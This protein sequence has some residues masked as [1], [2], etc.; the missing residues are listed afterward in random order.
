MRVIVVLDAG[1]DFISTF[2]ACLYC[3]M[4]NIPCPPAKSAHNLKLLQ[5]V[6]ADSAAD[7]LICQAH[8]IERFAE[9]LPQINCYTVADIMAL[10]TTPELIGG[11]EPVEPYQPQADDVAIIQYSSGSTAAPKG[12]LE[13]YQMIAHN[14]LVVKQRFCNPPEKREQF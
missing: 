4:T 12:V 6:A 10:A 1:I 11:N 9:A 7:A 2:L 3:G 13:T 8:N 5:T 14:H